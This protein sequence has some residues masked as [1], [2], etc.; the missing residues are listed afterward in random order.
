MKRRALLSGV[1]PAVAVAAGA[2]RSS[3]ADVLTGGSPASASLEMTHNYHVAWALVNQWLCTIK[4]NSRICRVPW[5]CD[6]VNKDDDRMVNAVS[7]GRIVRFSFVLK[8]EFAIPSPSIDS[9][10][11][12][13]LI[14]NVRGSVDEHL[15][16]TLDS[17]NLVRHRGLKF[18]EISVAG[19]KVSY[20]SFCE[21]RVDVN[22]NSGVDFRHY[23]L[24]KTHRIPMSLDISIRRMEYHADHTV[25]VEIAIDTKIAIDQ[26]EGKITC[27][28]GSYKGIRFDP[29]GIPLPL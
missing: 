16:T 15:S 22:D 6:C 29:P 24:K 21:C 11:D 7:K 5:A 17:M 13:M 2:C 1:V 20:G 19:E 27:V 4:N 14:E 12:M 26:H 3:V 23:Y 8:N 9:A 18:S 28:E 10:A 25:S